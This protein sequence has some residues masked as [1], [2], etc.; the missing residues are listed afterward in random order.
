MTTPRARPDHRSPRRAVA[1]CGAAHW[2]CRRKNSS[3]PGSRIA[4]EAAARAV[5]VPAGV[6]PAQAASS[7]AAA[8]AWE[9]PPSLSAA[10]RAAAAG[11]L[12]RAQCA[13]AVRAT[14]ARDV[15]QVPLVPAGA[16]APAGSRAT[17]GPGESPSDS[18]RGPSARCPSAARRPWRWAQAEPLRAASA[19]V[20]AAAA[21][22]SAAPAAAHG[23][24]PRPPPSAET[25][26]GVPSGA[27]ATRRPRRSAARSW[28]V[29]A[30]GSSA[31]RHICA[32]RCGPKAR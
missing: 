27:A 19:K 1:Q 13:A 18:A 16:P 14:A 6:A 32:G 22:R 21:P 11:T 2:A 23:P 3:A 8:A 4:A 31:E 17:E 24:A 29:L 7:V 28:R 10:A 5:D 25:G 9:A 26:Q 15:A 20:P 30:T 12:P